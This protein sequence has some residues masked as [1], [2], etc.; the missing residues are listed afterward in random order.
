MNDVSAFSLLYSVS[1]RFSNL[2][3][4]FKND[5][6]DGDL[7]ETKFDFYIFSLF[8]IFSHDFIIYISILLDSQLQTQ[9]VIT[10]QIMSH[11]IYYTDLLYCFAHFIAKIDEKFSLN[12]GFN[13][14]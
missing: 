9:Q 7:C 1:A 12:D 10:S 14:I 6:L 11:K 3:I 5:L 2:W 13:T 8:L 4:P